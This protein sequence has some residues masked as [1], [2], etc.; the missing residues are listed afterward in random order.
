M[1][2]IEHLGGTCIR[3]NAEDIPGL[4]FALD[5]KGPGG[6]S[7][8]CKN[9]HRV[10]LSDIRSVWFRRATKPPLPDVTSVQDDGLRETM[11][12]HMLMETKG[13]VANLYHALSH[14]HWLSHMDTARPDK[15]RVLQM[16]RAR[17]VPIPGTLVTNSKKALLDFRDQHEEIIIKC[18]TDPEVFQKDDLVYSS[19]T[20]V[21]EQEHID[22]LPERFFP[23][24]V[25][26]KLKK[27][28]EIRTFFLDGKCYSMAIF[29]QG[30]EQTEV[31]FRHYDYENP[32]RTV[33]YRLEEDLEARLALLMDDLS[34]ETGSLDL[35]R[36][37]DG[38]TY[39]LEVNPVGQFGMV[40]HPC[41]MFLEK[42]MA[43]FLAAK[44]GP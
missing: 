17:G 37:V 19:F 9:G 10:N 6:D 30:N 20:N 27:A 8:F 21:F 26:E 23:V 3:L 29:S 40:S 39:F 33:P 12:R 22:S 5:P 34:L 7:F 24:L 31:D 32:N 16:A 28:W 38:K 15:F 11:E 42:K 13:A 25:Q 41:N 43:A 1:E 36:G 4:A 2:W 18:I 35:I 14:A 44:D